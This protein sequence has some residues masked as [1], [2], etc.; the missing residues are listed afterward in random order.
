MKS[1]YSLEETIAL[2]ESG[3][4]LTI[5]G[6]STLLKKLPKGNWIGGSIPY[7]MSEIGGLRSKKVLQITVWP[8]YVKIKE[9]KYYKSNQLVDIPKDYPVNGLSFILIPSGSATHLV[10]AQDCSTWKGFF[11]RPILGWITGIDLNEQQTDKAMVI[12]GKTGIIS[13]SEALVMHINLPENIYS[14][15]NILNLF[16]QGQGDEISFEGSGFSIRDCFIN[17]KKRNFAE[18][19]KE[20]NLSTELPLVA[21]YQGALINVSFK[22]VNNTD[23][24]LYAPVFK[25][26]VYKTAKPLGLYSEQFEQEVSKHKV[27]P[28]FSCNCILNYLYAG[29]E[30][31]KTGDIKGPMTFGEIAYILLN[32]TMVYLT[33]KEKASGEE[34]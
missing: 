7:F 14:E 31:K 32:Q 3:K 12:N 26:V 8:D 23:V 19:I 25:G 21:N 20:N 34:S 22:S 11:D 9:I 16:S 6:D 15:I 4:V 10:Y 29:L 24:E 17:G 28:V 13:E 18:Y 2:I 30:G 33:F 5:A 27:K 1:L